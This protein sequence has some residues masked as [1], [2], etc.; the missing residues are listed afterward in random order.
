MALAG[1]G[2]VLLT[3]FTLPG[4]WMTL[5]VALLCQWMWG[6]PRLFDWWTIGAMAGLALLAEVLEAASSAVGASRSGG[7]KSGA[8]GSILGAIIGAIVGSFIIP[9]VGTI[10]GAVL[11]AGLGA[12][13]GERGI[14]GKTWAD[15]YKVGKGAASARAFAILLKTVVAAVVGAVLTAAVFL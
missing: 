14:A 8:F 10:V 12:V 9:I 13:A 1:A 3:L 2:G 5:L 7:G 4:V 15:S 11:G 6:E